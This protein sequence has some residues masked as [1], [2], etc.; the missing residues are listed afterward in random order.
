MHKDTV[1][2]D[3]IEG[4]LLIAKKKVSFTVT[5]GSF[6]DRREPPMDLVEV[7]EH[8]DVPGT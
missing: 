5:Y 3:L 2:Q 4:T 8:S 7:N 1:L 6:T